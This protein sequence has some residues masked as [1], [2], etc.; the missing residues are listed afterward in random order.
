MW[1]YDD[2]FVMISLLVRVYLQYRLPNNVQ[3]QMV[4]AHGI[5]S[6][7][8]MLMRPTDGDARRAK[9]LL[10]SMKIINCACIGPLKNPAANKKNRQFA[11]DSVANFHAHAPCLRCSNSS[12]FAFR[13]HGLGYLIAARPSADTL[14][15]ITHT[16]RSLA[17]AK[18]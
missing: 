9:T 5:H 1:N 17:R 13:L 8:I 7:R 12:K 18:A 10:F 11:C 2:P 14:H 15:L 6:W 3:R 16:Q 4:A